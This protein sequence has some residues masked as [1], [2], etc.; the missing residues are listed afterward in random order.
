MTDGSLEVAHDAGVGSPLAY[1]RQSV[2]E[3]GGTI[4]LLNFS[5]TTNFRFAPSIGYF[6]VDGLELTL[7]A[8]MNILHTGGSSCDAGEVGCIP[9]DGNTDVRFALIL[10]PSYHIP[11]SDAFYLF[12]GVGLGVQFARDPKADFIVRPKLGADLLVGRS[13]IFKPALFIDV[14]VNDGYAGFG[15]EGSFTAMW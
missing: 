5:R 1:A 7:F 9:E 15:L 13:A 11:L 10:E 14:G 4:G 2:V 8:D 3:V 12:G 6:I